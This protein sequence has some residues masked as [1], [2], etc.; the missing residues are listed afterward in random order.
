MEPVKFVT[1][2][3]IVYTFWLVFYS[4]QPLDTFRN[5]SPEKY[6]VENPK[7]NTVSHSYKV[8]LY[9]AW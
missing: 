3:I 2:L 5:K 9:S 4:P 8:R 6:N 1:F 7:V